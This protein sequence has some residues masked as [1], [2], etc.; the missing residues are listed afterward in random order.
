M[1]YLLGID[2][3]TTAIK[4][5]LFP[6]EDARAP[7]AVASRPSPTRMPR[8]GFSETDPKSVLAAIGECVRE[9]CGGRVGAD[10]AAI[11]ISGTACGAWLVNNGEPVRPPIL[12]NDGRA[13]QIVDDWHADG[14]MARIFDISGNAPFPGYTLPVLRWLIENE[15]ASLAAATDLLFCKDFVRGWLTGAW[16]TEES[17]ASYV[18]FDIA[19]RRWSPELFELTGTASHTH[20]IPDLSPP[21]RIDPLLPALARDLR[22]KEGIPVTMGATD[23]VA[24]CVGAGAVAAGH[25]VTILGTSANSSI[26]TDG[27]EFEPRG[28]G[29]MAA[30]PL[31]RWIRTMVNTSGSMTLDWAAGLLTG[32]DVGALFAHAASADTA[33]IPVLLPYLADAGVVSPFVDAKARGAFLGLRV[34]HDAA[35]MCRAVV[36]GLAFA[37]ADCYAAMPSE[38]RRITAVGGAARSDLLLQTLADATGATVLRPRGAEFGARGVALIAAL[39]SGMLDADGFQRAAEGLDIAQHF[40]PRGDAGD[41]KARL[42]RYRACSRDVRSTGRLW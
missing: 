5:A 20:L 15:P 26:V 41:V 27:P 17:D 25:A 40:E 18:P 8:P 33:D 28:I 29:I 24:G 10:V 3:G 37:V 31:G 9:I 21:G 22:L 23:I 16:T 30:A 36:D 14:R 4:A 12:W 35:A 38:V 6:L 11:G 13:T 1:T 42:D 32:G 39:H 2:V 19:G 34:G 7:I